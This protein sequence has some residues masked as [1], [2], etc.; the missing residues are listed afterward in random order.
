MSLLSL[1][2]VARAWMTAGAAPSAWTATTDLG[3]ATG[4]YQ[5]P[6]LR[7]YLSLLCNMIEAYNYTSD[8][9]GLFSLPPVVT[10]EPLR[11]QPAPAI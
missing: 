7:D 1:P 10:Y 5:G 8:V 3:R 9:S 4:W 11:S 2:M 6:A